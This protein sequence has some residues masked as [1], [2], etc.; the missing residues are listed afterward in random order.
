MFAHLR[1][2]PGWIP[3]IAEHAGLFIKDPPRLT[4]SRLTTL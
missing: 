1:A 2:Q 3:A 4:R